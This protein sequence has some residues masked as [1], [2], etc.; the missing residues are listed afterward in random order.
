MEHFK[1]FRRRMK[2]LPQVILHIDKSV[3]WRIDIWL[4]NAGISNY[5]RA[6]EKREEGRGGSPHS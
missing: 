3:Q 2:A 4:D 1:I 6:R 5:K